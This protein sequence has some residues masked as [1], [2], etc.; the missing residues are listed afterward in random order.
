L[1]DG[2]KTVIYFGSAKFNSNDLAAGM[3]K[4]FKGA[5]L[6]GCTTAGDV[7]SGKMLKQSVIAMGI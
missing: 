1:G 7:V 5:P 6:F 2:L 4:A 3:E